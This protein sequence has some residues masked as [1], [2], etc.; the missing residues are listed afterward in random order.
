MITSIVIADDK[1]NVLKKSKFLEEFSG[2]ELAMPK[3]R[4]KPEDYEQLFK[5]NIDDTFRIGIS[6]TKKSI[7]VRK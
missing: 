7:K 4:P 6:I 3:K 5:G 1:G 2:S